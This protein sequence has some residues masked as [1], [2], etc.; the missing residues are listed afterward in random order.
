MENKQGRYLRDTLTIVHDNIHKKRRIGEERDEDRVG[1]ELVQEQRKS[2]L[3]EL[4]P[5]V[6]SGRCTSRGDSD[7]DK[8]IK[9]GEGSN[10]EEEKSKVEVEIEDPLKCYKLRLEQLKQDNE[11]LKKKRTDTFKDYGRLISS[12][13]YGL[14][15][16]SKLKELSGAPDNVMEGNV[17]KSAF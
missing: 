10:A 3:K 7:I 8:E 13:E 1:H 9:E 15:Y 4:I 2:C 11:M 17:A 16:V 14:N 5:V 12:Y 6:I